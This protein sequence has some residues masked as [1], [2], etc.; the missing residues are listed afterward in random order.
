MNAKRFGRWGS[1]QLGRWLLATLLLALALPGLAAAIQDDWQGVERIVA[2]GDIHGDYDN[3]IAVLKNAGVINRRGRWAA[4]KTHVVQVGDIPDRG[5][6]TLKIIEHLQKL[7]K[8][9]LK[10]GGRLH[11]LIGN[12]EHMNITGDLRYVHPGEYEAF[13]NRNSKQLRKNYYAYVVKTIEQ[14]RATLLAGGDDASH[15]PVPDEDFKRDWYNEHPLGFVEH[16]LAWQQGGELFEWIAAHNTVI[17][18][19]DILFLHGGLSAELLPLSITDINE[20]VRAELNRDAFKGEPLGTSDN[21]PLWYRGLA[22]GDEA[23]VRPALDSVLAH[24]EAAMIVL[25]HTPD[26][27]AITP[28]FGG[29]VVIID[30][31]ISA[32]YGGHLAS[33]LIEDGTAT[34]I[35]GDHSLALP[36]NTAEILPYFE[37]LAA[38]MPKNPRLSAHIA[39]LSN[40]PIESGTDSPPETAPIERTPHSID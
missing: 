4:G 36:T 8:Q 25:G 32:Y 15:L 24:Y 3:Y 37:A 35:H 6:D 7:E 1:T 20:R 19:N 29:Q 2:I 31:G 5:P 38:E 21:G 13:E 26:L 40:P 17:R 22:R 33:L 27:N 34:A 18:I 10:A 11:L 28:R 16:R 14:Q 39:V 23:A 12:H 9:A 30:T